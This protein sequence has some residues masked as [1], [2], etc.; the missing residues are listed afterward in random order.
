[1]YD[2]NGSY[3]NDSKRKKTYSKSYIKVKVK[4]G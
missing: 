1:M 3:M 4:K 2:P